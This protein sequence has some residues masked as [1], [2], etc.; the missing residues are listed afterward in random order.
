MR[1]LMAALCL[2]RRI[3]LSFGS[4]TVTAIPGEIDWCDTTIWQGKWGNSICRITGE[5][6]REEA[7]KVLSLLQS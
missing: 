7:E 1:P 2:A 3:T 5:N 4:R 6:H